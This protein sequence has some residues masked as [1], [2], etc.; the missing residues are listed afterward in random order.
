M[1]ILVLPKT[2]RA[3]L[4]CVILAI[5]FAPAGAEGKLALSVSTDRPDAIYSTGDEVC[6]Q[7]KL[8]RGAE[9]VK[10]GSVGFV[11]S[12]DGLDQLDAGSVDLSG[13][14][15]VIK[16]RMSRPGFLRCRVTFET[17]EGKPL[18]ATAGAA[19]SPTEIEPS[20]PV[21]DDFD[22][23]W[24]DQKAELAKV[25]INP[26][27]TPVESKDDAIECFDVQLDC[28][29]GAPVSGYF[30]R[31]KAAKPKSLPAILYVHGAGVRSSSLGNA[32]SGAGHG[33]LAMDINAHGIP[34]GK[35]AAFYAEVNRGELANYRHRGRESR[36]TIYF[37]GMFLRLI[38]AID[39]LT[40]QPEWN[41][42]ILAVVGHSQGGGQA[43]AAGG[44][45]G[46]VTFIGV[47]VPAICDHSGKVIGRINGWPKLVPDGDDAKPEP[48]ILEAARYVDG[49]NMAGRVKAEA[50][51]SIGFIDPTCP[52]TTCYAAYNQLKGKKRVINEPL[53]GHAAPEHIKE[54]FMKAVLEHVGR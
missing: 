39:F 3:V 2:A 9:A 47:G 11:L 51:M 17:P 35:P 53:M 10:T 43:L 7:V 16:G 40:S 38:R 31:P 46:R 23:F 25:A 15:V 22:E 44:L 18:G 30:G 52:A 6:F 24:N 37:R 27:L 8:S 34:N 32:V 45:D 26:K 41:G 14:P 28:L 36:E 20:T 29:G 5:P 50:I 48:G 4:T 49:V 33:M 1:R 13:E 54:A 12:E 42:K 21:P 19:V